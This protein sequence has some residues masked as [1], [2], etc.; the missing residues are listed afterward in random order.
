MIGGEDNARYLL[1]V[2]KSHRLSFFTVRVLI[3]PWK[4]NGDI[5]VMRTKSQGEILHSALCFETC[6]MRTGVRTMLVVS[7]LRIKLCSVSWPLSLPRRRLPGVRHGGVL[8]WCHLWVFIRS[9]HPDHKMSSSHQDF[10]T[11]LHSWFSEYRSRKFNA[12]PFCWDARHIR[13]LY[14]MMTHTCP[15]LLIG[16]FIICSHLSNPC[17]VQLMRTG[18]I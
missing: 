15:Y 4:V 7:S 12:L 18:R 9:P 6:D 14:N 13:L 11:L 1:L 17:F 10:T 5:L 3:S 16:F 2:D 8:I